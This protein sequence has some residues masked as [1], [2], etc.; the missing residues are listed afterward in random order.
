MQTDNANTSLFESNQQIFVLISFFS[1]SQ[2]LRLQWRDDKSSVGNAWN[3]ALS[4]QAELSVLR[5]GRK[6]P[7]VT[8]AVLVRFA[9]LPWGRYRQIWKKKKISLSNLANEILMLEQYYKNYRKPQWMQSVHGE[10]ST[11]F[12]L[13]KLRASWDEGR[14]NGTDKQSRRH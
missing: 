9:S 11:V 14:R 8:D 7:W 13:F 2:C 12:T 6:V 1:S 3:S 4:V 5:W 10:D